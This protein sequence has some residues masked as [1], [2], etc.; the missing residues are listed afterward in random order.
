MKKYAKYSTTYPLIN[1]LAEFI[2]RLRDCAMGANSTASTWFLNPHRIRWCSVCLQYLEK[3]KTDGH[4]KIREITCDSAYL[5]EDYL[6]KDKVAFLVLA[7]Y[8]NTAFYSPPCPWHPFPEQKHCVRTAQH[9]RWLLLMGPTLK[10]DSLQAVKFSKSEGKHIYP[11][12][13]V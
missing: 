5:K 4:K 11:K 9:P 7:K 1:S 3:L 8:S 13:S 6:D 10:Q 12:Q 2:V